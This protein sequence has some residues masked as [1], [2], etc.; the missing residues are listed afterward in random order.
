MSR[1]ATDS[2]VSGS[3]TRLL[4]REY[5]QTA[6]LARL[7]IFAPG[8]F[9]QR[10]A[11]VTRRDPMAV[12]PIAQVR[13]EAADAAKAAVRRGFQREGNV[14]WLIRRGVVAAMRS[15]G[16]SGLSDP[17]TAID[18][19]LLVLWEEPQVDP[20]RLP[21]D[22]SWLTIGG[23]DALIEFLDGVLPL[24]D[25]ESGSSLL[26]LLGLEMQSV[27][28]VE[29]LHS[30]SELT[31]SRL[32]LA[33][34]DRWF[35]HWSGVA[36]DGNYDL[37]KSTLVDRSTRRSEILRFVADSLQDFRDI[38]HFRVNADADVFEAAASV[39]SALLPEMKLSEWDGVS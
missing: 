6:A 38:R 1:T 22:G 3:P 9:A 14:D 32:T 5:R 28:Q 17:W 10:F 29:G 35:R 37:S 2:C 21:R 20:A 34:R 39:V 33:S 15:I 27:I 30:G 19:W 24:P 8:A 11:R 31:V 26:Q 12:D 25:E 7:R 16:C 4:P 18:G 36:Q 23:D 13:D